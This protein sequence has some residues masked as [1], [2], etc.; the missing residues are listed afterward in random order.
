[1]HALYYWNENQLDQMR[2]LS[3]VSLSQ[4]VN[5]VLVLEV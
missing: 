4:K 3:S 1:M 5:V 2:W